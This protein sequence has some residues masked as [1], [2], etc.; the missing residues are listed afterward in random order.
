[1]VDG[2]AATA[3]EAPA[4]DGKWFAGWDVDFSAVTGDITVTA[5]YK[6]NGV[7][8][9]VSNDELI[10]LGGK[11]PYAPFA[12]GA[13]NSWN[14][15]LTLEVG[16]FTDIKD[17]GWAAFNSESFQFGYIINGG[18]P[19]WA[20]AYTV[21]AGQDIWNAIGSMATNCSRF[22]GMLNAAALQLGDNNVKFCVK[23]DGGVVEILREYT[24][25]LVEPAP[26]D[27]PVSSY[28]VPQDI[29]TVSGHCTGIISSTGH[30]NSPMVAAGGVQSGALLHQGSVGVGLIDLSKYSKVIIYV[31][32]DNSKVTMDHHAANANNRIMLT[33]VDT[34]MTMSPAQDKVIASTDY[35][36]MGWKVTPI[37][38]DLTG[39][40]YEGPV[41]VTY[42]TLPGTFMLFSSIEFI[43]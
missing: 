17:W 28:D 43:A 6:D 22:S 7:L 21:V 36:P 39:V 9:H 16:S 15:K 41:Y 19:I 37:E 29:W 26:E 14:G 18:A 3:P 4:V 31:G 38:I 35:T 8:K 11:T 40:D 27:E 23:L 42:D 33:S 34:N 13:Y 5:I 25:T 1:M 2:A 24:V 20:D 32:V 10:A 12:P 30:P